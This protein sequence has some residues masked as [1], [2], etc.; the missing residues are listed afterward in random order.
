MDALAAT[1]PAVAELWALAA[2]RLRP[3]RQEARA[4]PVVAVQEEAVV[5]RPLLRLR[6]APMAEPVALAVV[7]AVV[8][9]SA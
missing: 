6:L 7:V 4:T 8:V 2:R 3:V 1:R 5:E 9:E